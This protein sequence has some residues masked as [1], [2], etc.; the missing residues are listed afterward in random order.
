[1]PSGKAAAR[2]STRRSTGSSRKNRGE[3]DAARF[4]LEYLVTVAERPA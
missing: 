2:S 3:P 1:M 4:E